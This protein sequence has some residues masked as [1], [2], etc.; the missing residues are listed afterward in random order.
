VAL[1]DFNGDGLLDITTANLNSDNVSVIL[2]RGFVSIGTRLTDSSLPPCDPNSF[3]LSQDDLFLAQPQS[4]CRI[5]RLELDLT[6]SPDAQ[7]S[8][9]LTSPSQRT[10]GLLTLPSPDFTTGLARPEIIAELARFESHPLSGR[11]ALGTAGFEVDSARMLVN[12]FPTDPF[13]DDPPDDPLAEVC[14]SDEDQPDDPDFTC[15]LDGDSL[16]G[17]VL[18]DDEDED[19]FL[20]EGDF[21]GAFI[22]GQTFN[23]VVD[24]A[25]EADLSVELRALRASAPLEVA[26]EIAPGQWALSFTVPPDYS[27]R[28]FA[29]HVFGRGVVDLSYDVGVEVDF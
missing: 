3:A 21:D 1:G 25:P 6:L 24:T 20:L 8:L 16:E 15:R 11:W 7:G 28:Y 12:V 29:L 18:E 10:L 19:V 22:Q 17:S 26:Q 14:N 5:D 2:S 27:G 9:A 4:S 13:S 23:I